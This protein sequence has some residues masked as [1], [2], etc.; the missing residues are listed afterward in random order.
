MPFEVFDKKAVPNSAEAW[1]T[2][3]KRGN[4]SFNRKAIEA[5]GNPEAVELLYDRE[6]KLIGFR[7]ASPG[8]P[9]A[10]PVR[11]T[12]NSGTHLVAG[13]AFS[14]HYG[15]PTEEARRFSPKLQD[16]MLVIDLKGDYEVATGPRQ[17]EE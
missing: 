13:M 10:Y 17:K 3:Q 7:P 1:V 15:I 6:N 12:G 5:F 16:G 2:L 8:A 9:R 14:Q 4:F 11:K